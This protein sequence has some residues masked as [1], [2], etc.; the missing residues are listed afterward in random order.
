M[1]PTGEHEFLKEGSAVDKCQVHAGIGPLNPTLKSE[2]EGGSGH[3]SRPLGQICPRATCASRN[4]LGRPVRKIKW[5]DLAG[6]LRFF[7]KASSLHSHTLFILR[8][9]QFIVPQVPYAVVAP[10][11]I[12]C[13]LDGSRLSAHNVQYASPETSCYLFSKRKRRLKK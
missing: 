10:Q 3:A 9:P 8:R 13:T 2:I 12:A 6:P 4:V 5:S 1:P 7:F 11:H